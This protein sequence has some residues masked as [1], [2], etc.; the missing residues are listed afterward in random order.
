ME[1]RIITGQQ[2][3]ENYREQFRRLN[4]ALTYGFNLEAIFIEYSIIEDRTESILRHADLWEKYL[5]KRGERGPNLDSKIKYINNCAK[6]KVALLEKYFSDDT[7]S[8]IE[9]WKEERNRLIHALLQ[10]NLAHNEVSNVAEKGNNLVKKLRNKTGSYNRMIE[11]KTS[12]T[13]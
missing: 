7:L 11:K 1:E 4:R 13:E 3:F 10:Q 5:K 6:S 8:E 2:K 9:L 12:K